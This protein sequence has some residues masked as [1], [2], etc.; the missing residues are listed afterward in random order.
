[1]VANLQLLD[2]IADATGA[3]RLHGG[4]SKRIRLSGTLSVWEGSLLLVAAVRS[5]LAILATLWTLP[6]TGRDLLMVQL[7]VTASCLVAGLVLIR[8]GVGDRRAVT[9]AGIL[10]TTAGATAW[11]H[12]SRLFVPPAG[13][14][15]DPLA[16]L[17]PEAL[18]AYWI[19]A[20]VSV[21]PR[22]VIAG[23]GD[24]LFV[25]GRRSSL[26]WGL[27]LLA[28]HA[29]GSVSPELRAPLHVL[30]R[31]GTNFW[32]WGV[33]G[34]LTLA[35]SP[36]MLL[37]ARRAEGDE[38]RRAAFFLASVAVGFGPLFA[39]EVAASALGKTQ[40]SS[41]DLALELLPCL[42]VPFTTS[43]FILVKKMLPLRTLLHQTAHHFLARTTLGVALGLPLLAAVVVLII[44]RDRPV[45]EALGGSIFVALVALAA[46]VAPLALFRRRLIHRMDRLFNREPEDW[47]GHLVGLTR[48]MTGVASLKATLEAIQE[49]VARP[50]G[51]ESV[52]V[53]R[54]SEDARILVPTRCGPPHLQ[55]DAGP[56]LLAFDSDEPLIVDA[57]YDDAA[58]WWLPESDRR[59]I[60][61]ANA[62]LLLALVAGEKQI[63]LVVLG[64]RRAARGYEKEEFQFLRAV[65]ASTAAVVE[66]LAAEPLAAPPLALECVDCGLVLAPSSSCG[67][68]GAL[69]EARLPRL[70]AS[71]YEIERRV[72]QGGMGTVYS[73]LD[74]DL[75]RRVA[76][77]TL[78][79]VSSGASIRLRQEARAM[80]G[81]SHPNLAVLYGIERWNAAPV[82]V[83]EFMGGGML[84]ARIASRRL[85]IGEIVA[86]G[87]AMSSALEALHAAAF[88]HRDVKP[89]NIGFSDRG[90]PK[91]LD[92]GLAEVALRLPG[93]DAKGAD[94]L[95]SRPSFAGTPRYAPPESWLGKPVGP[96]GDLWSL[97]M[98]LYECLAGSHPLAG[99]PR[100]KWGKIIELLPGPGAVRPDC[101]AGLADVVSVGLSVDASRR[102]RL[103]S[104]VRAELARHA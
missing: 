92:L 2:R 35:A 80:A 13:A 31:V 75:G 27:F 87:V 28:G 82:L 37:A 22:R 103:A 88:V 11:P 93:A 83:S 67:C 26:A 100:A 16:V 58:F 29:A 73:A 84:S 60:I 36:A 95:V 78:P 14:I 44:R 74:S 33:I 89:S 86:L 34:L 68:G 69:R 54:M 23:L 104:E 32:F 25:L 30:A 85:D 46:A 96:E 42:T 10:L 40:A 21:F 41:F 98:V 61:D 62:G 43:Y 19:W 90:E 48:G 49:H 65:A 66:R 9:L 20:F 50:L 101:P 51:V 3:R 56:A 5:I 18:F 70:L 53:F 72:G 15:F 4:E 1:M 39:M 81:V 79:V 59:W 17:L 45:G 99:A 76:L 102:W 52:D 12:Y 77:K 57:A 97:A 71:R 63:G 38:R 94:A 8:G 64:P 55:A 7:A 47:Q 6:D 24:P 91:L